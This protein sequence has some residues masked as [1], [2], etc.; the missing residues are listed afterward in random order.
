MVAPPDTLGDSEGIYAEF[1]ESIMSRDR[2]VLAVLALAGLSLVLVGVNIGL[3]LWNQQL[4]FQVAERQQFI[5]E[6]T[7]YRRIGEAL[8]RSLTTIG[9]S[10]RDPQLA[11]LMQ[12]HG[13][14]APSAGG[15][16]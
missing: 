12:R 16:K 2:V 3:S 14:A 6:Q 1:R 5:G 13:I 7:E 10:S 11:A 15:G 9:A 4:Q 8:I